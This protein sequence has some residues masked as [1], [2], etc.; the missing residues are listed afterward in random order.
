[1]AKKAAIK[2]PTVSLPKDLSQ[3]T[4]TRTAKADFYNSTTIPDLSPLKECQFV[5][6]LRTPTNPVLVY[7][8]KPIVR[9]DKLKQLCVHTQDLSANHF[10]T[11]K[12]AII[13]IEETECCFCS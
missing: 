10:S 2:T 4:I 8:S 9:G 3:L 13:S 1:M 12:H 11:A 7:L 5:C 6:R